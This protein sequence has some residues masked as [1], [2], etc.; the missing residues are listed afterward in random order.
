MEND[1][2]ASRVQF[3]SA[4]VETLEKVV[5]LYAREAPWAVSDPLAEKNP[6]SQN[7]T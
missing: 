7:P 3:A 6:N 2:L 4:S 1:D 5:G